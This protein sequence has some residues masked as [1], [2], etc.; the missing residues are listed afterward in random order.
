M[1]GN[2]IFS[3]RK[4]LNPLA[5]HA[6]RAGYTLFYIEGWKLKEN[7]RNNVAKNDELRFA[8]YSLNGYN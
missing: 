7:E 4:N 3:S 6:K 2:K 8:R 5:K 1:E